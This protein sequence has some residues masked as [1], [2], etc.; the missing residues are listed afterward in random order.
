MGA[1]GYQASLENFP[2]VDADFVPLVGGSDSLNVDLHVN[3]ICYKVANA[4]QARSHYLY[5]PAIT[6]NTETKQAIIKDTNYLKIY[7]IN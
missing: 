1:I 7:G 3:T 2:A 6:K 5:A 4:F